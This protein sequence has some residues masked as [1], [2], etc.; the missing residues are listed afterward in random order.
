ME[1]IDN[2]LEVILSAIDSKNLWHHI[3]NKMTSNAKRQLLGELLNT[4]IGSI[5]ASNSIFVDPRVKNK[6][7]CV[8]A[9]KFLDYV[10]GIDPTFSF[11]VGIKRFLDDS[12]GL[13]CIIV[14][15]NSRVESM[16]IHTL[17]CLHVDKDRIIPV[18]L[19]DVLKYC[20]QKDVSGGTKNLL[21]SYPASI[22]ITPHCYQH[23]I[24]D[25]CK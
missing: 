11:C 1:K 9:L 12:P 21:E 13:R 20:T 14:Y 8:E 25:L 5:D 3:Y 6:E 17:R 24:K 23:I 15:P 19:D 7:K 16:Y 10:N 2:V 18:W 22:F 4:Y